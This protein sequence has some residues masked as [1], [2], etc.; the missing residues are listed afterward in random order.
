[1]EDFIMPKPILWTF[2][3]LITIFALP[4]SAFTQERHI[5]Y[6]FV[7]LLFVARDFWNNREHEEN[8]KALAE[9]LELTETQTRALRTICADALKQQNRRMGSTPTPEAAERI[10]EELWT[11]INQVFRPAQQMKFKE[12][13]FQVIGGFDMPVGVSLLEFLNLTADQKEKLHKAAADTTKECRSAAMG[14]ITSSCFPASE[15]DPE[16]SSVYAARLAE[17]I[18]NHRKQVIALLTAEQ[19]AHVEN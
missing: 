16:P 8:A 17:G 11:K 18:A 12:I 1:M 15:D 2:A 7:Q 3:V 6:S 10:R 9:M 13:I 14:L 4:H 5:E 19:K